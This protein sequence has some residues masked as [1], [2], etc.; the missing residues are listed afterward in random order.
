[1]K[2]FFSWRAEKKLKLRFDGPIGAYYRGVRKDL[3]ENAEVSWEQTKNENAETTAVKPQLTGRRWLQFLDGAKEI[4]RSIS[5]WGKGGELDVF[6]LAKK[7]GF[8]VQPYTD[9]YLDEV[10]R[11]PEY[12]KVFEDAK[13][14]AHIIDGFS[15]PGKRKIF[16][17]RTIT[18]D[19]KRFAIAH[20]LSHFLL[21]HKGLVFCKVSGAPDS[22]HEH[23]EYNEEADKLAAISL[24]P[25]KYIKKNPEKSDEEIAKRFGV[26]EHAVKK[27][28]QEVDI[29]FYMLRYGSHN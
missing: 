21:G 25:H 8:D 1:M 22:E 29:E 19:R 18:D 24:M 27:R 13:K 6:K 5:L 23:K 16:Y 28:R 17:N 3:Q 15:F 2:C 26:S 10:S 9:E 4:T 20:E 12:K 7:C 11:D 14:D